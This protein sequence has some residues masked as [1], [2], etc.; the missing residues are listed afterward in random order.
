LNKVEEWDLVH[1]LGEG[2]IVRIR[3]KKK[4]YHTHTHKKECKLF[5]RET[6]VRKCGHS[7]IANI[8]AIK[9]EVRRLARKYK[10]VDKRC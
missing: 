10:E 1:T 7:F 3:F 4:I 8:V 2:S 5:P 9:S 6:L